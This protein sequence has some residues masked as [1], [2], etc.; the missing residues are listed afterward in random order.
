MSSDYGE[1]HEFLDIGE[2]DADIV[3]SNQ[4]DIHA[5]HTSLGS[6]LDH[7][8]EY[9]AENIDQCPLDV[10]KQ[11][12][13]SAQDMLCSYFFKFHLNH[14]VCDTDV[15]SYEDAVRKSDI[16]LAPSQDAYVHDMDTLIN[17][18][19][20][21]SWGLELWTM[22]LE[23]MTELNIREKTYPNAKS[24]SINNSRVEL[25]KDICRV[26]SLFDPEF[27][28]PADTLKSE[29]GLIFHRI[30]LLMREYD[31]LPDKRGESDI[32]V[33]IH[34][35]CV[36]MFFFVANYYIWNT[37]QCF[38]AGILS[39][40]E[41]GIDWTQM[42][43]ATALLQSAVDSYEPETY[44][45]VRA[46]KLLMFWVQ[47]PLSTQMY[48][49]DK[50]FQI[51][52]L[53]YKNQSILVLEKNIMFYNALFHFE[54]DK[55]KFID[56][57]FNP[58]FDKWSYFWSGE[59]KPRYFYSTAFDLLLLGFIIQK[60]MGWAY[61]P[62]VF[63][64]T[65]EECAR[66]WNEIREFSTNVL[67]VFVFLNPYIIELVMNGSRV[68]GAPRKLIAI[69]IKQMNAK[70]GIPSTGSIEKMPW[71]HRN[72]FIFKSLKRDKIVV[73]AKLKKGIFDT[74]CRVPLVSS[75]ENPKE[76][77]HK[78][79]QEFEREEDDLDTWLSKLTD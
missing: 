69:W 17:N 26:I 67:P 52:D 6:Y 3:S 68:Q 2:V 51:E 72:L 10:L 31:H 49:F 62:D 36:T 46:I 54:R 23:L 20:Y 38:P 50:L 57:K 22:V 5:I 74:T 53:L 56:E 76:T 55:H 7:Y 14:S 47:F 66:F 41:I 32:H 48:I 34:E 63:V 9:V 27:A 59:G 11:S 33:L 29:I 71:V 65:T 16:S 61:F 8:A 1:W 70:E 12:L 4:F 37:N 40:D 15:L 75:S 28:T 58:D 35:R 30:G 25:Y 18:L 79:R 44:Q 24:Y 21:G 19:D 77:P 43:D 39:C 73:R 42:Q 78:T 13:K 45:S 64:V 60:F